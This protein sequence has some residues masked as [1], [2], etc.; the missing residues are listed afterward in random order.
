MSAIRQL[1]VI[2]DLH[3]EDIRLGR[4]L[5]FLEHEG[6]CDIICTGDI[7]DGRGCVDTSIRLLR[8]HG[9][10]TVRG[11]HDRWLL[12]RK[13]RHVPNAHHRETLNE[14]SIAFLE[15]LPTQIQLNTIAGSV[16]LCHG[17]GDNDLRK[18]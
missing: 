1:G 8:D 13:A 14:Q 6:A 10:K 7:A 4:A 5:E 9:V 15:N 16:L 17:V 11:N 18:V 2:G 12:E 3:S